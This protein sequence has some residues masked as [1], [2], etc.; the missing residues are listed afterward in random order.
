MAS[1]IYSGGVVADQA[2]E[3]SFFNA[4]GRLKD[5]FWAAI[6][7]SKIVPNL[8]WKRLEDGFAKAKGGS[9]SPLSRPS[10]PLPVGENKETDYGINFLTSLPSHWL[11]QDVN[12]IIPLCH[13]TRPMWTVLRPF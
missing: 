3:K 8:F 6:W 13:E 12:T 2:E 7:E 9:Q 4:R 10:P 1:K 5:L 11:C